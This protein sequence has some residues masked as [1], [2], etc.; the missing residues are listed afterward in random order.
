M[1]DWFTSLRPFSVTHPLLSPHYSASQKKV[2]TFQKS[3]PY[4]WL[5]IFSGNLSDMWVAIGLFYQMIPK[6]LTILYA[7]VS[8]SHICKL[9]HHPGLTGLYL[10]CLLS[11]TFRIAK[12][13]REDHSDGLMT[14]YDRIC[15]VVRIFW[16][17]H[18]H[19]KLHRSINSIIE[20]FGYFLNSLF[21]YTRINYRTHQKVT[22][23]LNK[24]INSSMKHKCWWHMSEYTHNKSDSFIKC[25]QTIQWLWF[26]SLFTIL[27]LADISTKQIPIPVKPRFWSIFQLWILLT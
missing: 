22:K 18:L 2:Y 14:I 23:T 27:N 9:D 10:F 3:P 24:V 26:R 20:H 19:F 15:I 5:Q 13:L 25:H 21:A 8:R 1:G 4:K 7:W 17:C 6:H 12:I 11:A 16:H